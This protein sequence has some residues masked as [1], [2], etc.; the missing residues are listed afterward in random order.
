MKQFLEFYLYVSVLMIQVCKDKANHYETVNKGLR[1]NSKNEYSAMKGK[2]MVYLLGTPNKFAR[3][4]LI[5]TKILL[6]LIHNKTA[7][8]SNVIQLSV[9]RRCVTIKRTLLNELF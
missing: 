6:Y 1:N 3:T 7:D 9:V 8:Q 2:S 5:H 4:T